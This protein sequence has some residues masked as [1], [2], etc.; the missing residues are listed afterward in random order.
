MGLPNYSD[1]KKVFD[2]F[3]SGNAGA[4]T[5]MYGLVDVWEGPDPKA[6]HQ[7]QSSSNTAAAIETYKNNVYL[8]YGVGSQSWLK[9]IT[10]DGPVI[11]D[12][13]SILCLMSQNVWPTYFS[14]TVLNENEVIAGYLYLNL[15]HQFCA[16]FG[17]GMASLYKNPSFSISN[18]RVSDTA[19][20]TGIRDVSGWHFL[21]YSKAS[22]DDCLPC[23]TKKAYAKVKFECMEIDYT[24]DATRMDAY[25]SETLTYTGDGYGAAKPLPTIHPEKCTKAMNQYATVFNHI[26]VSP[27]DVGAV[28]REISRY[29][30]SAMYSNI[31]NVTEYKTGSEIMKDKYIDKLLKDGENDKAYILSE[32]ARLAGMIGGFL[33]EI[34]DELGDNDFTKSL[35]RDTV[36]WAPMWFNAN[37][38]KVNEIDEERSVYSLLYGVD[39][40]D[41]FIPLI[42]ASASK[43]KGPKPNLSK[44]GWVIV[45]K[46]GTGVSKYGKNNMTY[47][48]YPFALCFSGRTIGHLENN[49]EI[50]GVCGVETRG[51][52]VLIWAWQYDTESKLKCYLYSNDGVLSKI[53]ETSI[54]TSPTSNAPMAAAIE[55]DKWL[56]EDFF[57]SDFGNIDSVVSEMMISP[58]IKQMT[59]A[60]DVMW[61]GNI[62]ELRGSW[63]VPKYAYDDGLLDPH[64]GRFD[65]DDDR[66]KGNDGRAWGNDGKQFDWISGYSGY[67]IMRADLL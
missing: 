34:R 29:C 32:S 33:Y 4:N 67:Q 3:W 54:T 25:E 7:S 12:I 11:Y 55:G 15:E 65:L 63:A 2:E 27:E 20:I 38:S 16:P 23:E 57:L 44:L 9:V 61:Y 52:G 48:R 50:D 58:E 60:K 14:L 10:P 39:M 37:R 47:F 46:Y 43:P 51:N 1:I 62:N 40:I 30:N 66:V 35:M 41:D 18:Y 26:K 21:I 17:I 13:G 19:W 56:I 6:K 59:D 8:L 31:L 49:L 28:G 42:Q 53:A 5:S 24:H 45:G 22:A 64:A 36:W